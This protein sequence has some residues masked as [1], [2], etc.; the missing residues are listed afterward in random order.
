MDKVTVVA[1]GQIS[2]IKNTDYKA[3]D[4]ETEEIINVIDKRLQFQFLNDEDE[5]EDI[6]VKLFDNENMTRFRAGMKIK[7]LV[8]ISSNGYILF[9]KQASEITE[10]I[11]R[12]DIAF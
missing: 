7:M 3:F 9:Y 4:D 1:K 11:N 2:F 5:I 12:I 6:E 10:D 8:E